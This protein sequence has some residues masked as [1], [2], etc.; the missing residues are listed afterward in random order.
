M[1]GTK[2]P[3]TVQLD[4]RVYRT[5][6]PSG[7][8]I[9]SEE[10]PGVRSASVGIWVRWGSSHEPADRLGISHLLE[11]MVFKGTERRSAKEIAREI[12]GIG[13]SLDA[14]TTREHTAYYAR[15]LDEDLS[16]AVDVLADLVFRPRLREVDLDLEKNVILEEIASIEDAPEDQVFDLHAEALWGAH[17]YG[18][19]VLGTR[20]TVETITIGDLRAVLASAY[21]PAGCVIAAAGNLRHERLVELVEEAFPADRLATQVPDVPD[22][23]DVPADEVRHAREASQ[24]HICVGSSTFAHGDPRR[25]GLILASTALGGGMSSR[26]FQRVRE[27]LGLAYVVYSFQSFYSRAGQVGIYLATR[28]ETAERALAEVRS[29]LADLSEKGL[30]EDELEGVRDQAKGQVMLSLEGTS[31]R[32]HRL[33]GVALYEEPYLTLDELCAR[34]DAV[35]VEEVAELARTYYA[36]K[37]Q[38]IVLLGPP[39]GPDGAAIGDVGGGP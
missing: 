25:Y 10:V 8:S 6:L 22:P 33:A 15:V 30:A 5:D 29:E 32:M 20:E 13:G 9:L 24:V 14:Y 21:R 1:T 11:H 17:P 4:E 23:G 39:G 16:V 34:I 18:K 12:E 38:T 19:P 36:P 31:S 2:T 7:P 3:T 27:E 26:L 37:R 35:T 28:P